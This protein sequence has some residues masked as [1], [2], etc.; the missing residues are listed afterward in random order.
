MKLDVGAD[1]VIDAGF[2]RG[3]VE[4][5]AELGERLVVDADRHAGACGWFQDAPYLE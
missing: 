1:Q 3:A 2:G 5:L 4:D